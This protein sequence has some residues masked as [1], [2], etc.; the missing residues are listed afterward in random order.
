MLRFIG[1]RG[2]LRAQGS[3]NHP[4]VLPGGALPRPTVAQTRDHVAIEIDEEQHVAEA[5]A[6]ILQ[7]YEVID[8]TKDDIP[9]RRQN[10]GQG[11][12]LDDI[13]LE[14]THRPQSLYKFRDVELKINTCVEL[15]EPVGN[16]Q[17]QFVEIKSIWA[18]RSG[19]PIIIRG[20][21]YTR[22]RNLRGVL[23][24][25]KNEI[26]QIL[27]VDTDD[28]RPDQTQALLEI[29]L[30]HILKV[31]T[32][33]KTNATFPQ[34]YIGNDRSGMTP[35]D[36]EQ[37]APLIC[38]W[39]YRIEYR[40]ARF[41]RRDKPDGGALI[42]MT[43]AEASRGFVCSDKELRVNWR[44]RIKRGG[45]FP[46]SSAVN[47][48]QY[49]FADVFCGAGGTTRGAVMAGLKLFFGVDKWPVSCAT[50]RRN[51]PNAQLFEQDATDF[52]HNRE[53]DYQSQPIDILHLSPPC[54]FWS[55]LAYPHAGRNNEENMAILFSCS[56]L[57][58]KI[59]PLLFTLEQTFG[60]THDAHAAF[61]SA[62]IQGFTCRGYSVQWKIVPL[63]EYGLPQTR[64]R[65]IIIGACPGEEL[66]PWPPATHSATP[67]RGQKPLVTE[68]QAIRDLNRHRVSLHNV[69]HTLA[70]NKP[71]RNGNLPLTK[72]ITCSQS[73]LHFSGR[74]DY[75]LREIACLQGF[76][77]SHEFEGNRTAIKKQI[78]N[79]FPSCVV[80]VLYEHLRQWLERKDGI[81]TSAPVPQA[82]SGSLAHRRRRSIPAPALPIETQ[83]RM[84]GNLDG[85]AAL[86]LALQESK[87]G[88]QSSVRVIELSDDEGQQDSPVAAVVAPLLERMSIAPPDLPLGTGATAAPR[89]RSRS[90]TLDF[91]PGPSSPSKSASQKRSLE[92]MHDGEVDD[93]M[94]EESPPKRE[95][96][97]ET[98]VEGGPVIVGKIPSRLPRYT[99][100]DVYD[101]GDEYVVV[102][103]SKRA[104]R[105]GI[106]NLYVA[107]PGNQDSQRD[108][109]GPA[110][111]QSRFSGLAILC[112]TS[113]A[114]ASDDEAWMF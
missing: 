16:W 29:S 12:F 111:S 7:E 66:P 9:Q 89:S 65:L 85:D 25:K 21:P 36:Q 101:A 83:H 40:A 44:G 69:A 34:F 11:H 17:V 54:Q 72:T 104:S 80:K 90:A 99:R 37:E 87:R 45:S 71:P 28:Q 86:R 23:E 46:T 105:E 102:G 91:S 49:T 35:S 19:G 31:R 50:W 112:R 109:V 93:V 10:Q 27:E 42:R 8:L 56:E 41:R 73:L 18:P 76:P 13:S 2:R 106:Q 39:K 51:F 96:A 114:V 113:K 47:K 74:R 108:T 58:L 59:R 97:T 20:L 61:F 4:I 88:P 63:V 68:A 15:L 77:V 92:S 110:S 1:N 60:L 22:S 5:E 43:E 100:H 75:T 103:N 98:R 64:K 67:A 33:H 6:A 84:N 79:A 107:I 94:E 62:L 32:L 14:A 38:R 30:E 53:I 81:H 78:G 55:P 52:I 70:R 26:C 82:M 24:M 3:V 48:R 57:I 95:R